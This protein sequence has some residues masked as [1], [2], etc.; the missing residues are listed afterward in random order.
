MPI[1][2]VFLPMADSCAALHGG[3][4]V[5]FTGVDGKLARGAGI[6]GKAEMRTW[7]AGAS[8]RRKT[9]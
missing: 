3:L 2:G 9:V 7:R 4:N 1:D 6:R 8:H 5:S